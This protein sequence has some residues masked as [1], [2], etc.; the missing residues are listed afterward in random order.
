M[1]LP[2]IDSPPATGVRLEMLRLLGAPF[3]RLHLLEL[4]A[5][6]RVGRRA[7]G[8]D[9]SPALVGVAALACLTEDGAG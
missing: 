2:P 8:D 5:N 3:N 9:R 6:F 1:P 4:L 7:R